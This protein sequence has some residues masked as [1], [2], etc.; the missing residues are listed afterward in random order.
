ML[1][2]FFD[3][4]KCPRCESEMHPAYADDQYPRFR[5]MNCGLIQTFC[6]CG[7]EMIV[8]DG[9]MVCRVCDL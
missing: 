9:W 7:A 5:C 4:K 8:K 1:K 3:T 6:K 2:C